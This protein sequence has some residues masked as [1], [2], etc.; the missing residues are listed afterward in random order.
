MTQTKGRL[1]D[2]NEEQTEKNDLKNKK[3][4]PTLGCFRGNKI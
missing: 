1:V 2:T 4:R 3:V